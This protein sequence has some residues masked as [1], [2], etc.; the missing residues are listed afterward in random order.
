MLSGICETANS[1]GHLSVDLAIDHLISTNV[2]VPLKD[3]PVFSPKAR[4]IV[5]L[6]ISW[7]CMIYSLPEG[8]TAESLQLDE[9][10]FVDLNTTRQEISE[11]R[12]PICEVLQQFGTLLPVKSPGPVIGSQTS[13]TSFEKNTLY[14]SLLNA[15]TLCDIGHV[16]IKWVDNVSSHLRFDKERRYLLLFSLPSLCHLNR[17]ENTTFSHIISD[18][19]DQYSKPDNFS[20]V[21]FLKEVGSPTAYFSA[22]TKEGMIISFEFLAGQHS[23]LVFVIRT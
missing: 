16:E 19:Y 3:D 4:H 18:Y 20:V 12:N 17:H 9:Q 11:A 6:A 21:A 14:V 7:I 2:F 13:D 22:M 10:Q 15:R 23:A 8:E 5:Y 1:S